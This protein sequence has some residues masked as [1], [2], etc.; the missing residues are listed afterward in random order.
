MQ[1]AVCFAIGDGDMLSSILVRGPEESELE[2][3][4]LE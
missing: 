4:K 1:S 2:P 3:C